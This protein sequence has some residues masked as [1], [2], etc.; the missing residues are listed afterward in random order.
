MYEKKTT[1]GVPFKD[2]DDFD[3]TTTGGLTYDDC[4]TGCVP[5]AM[6]DEKIQITPEALKGGF[7]ADAGKSRV[8]LIPPEVILELGKLYAIGAVKY[9]DDNW[10]LGMDYKRVY[11]AMQRHALKWWA[12]EELD[13]VDGQHHLDSVIWCAVALRYYMLHY[14]KYKDFDSRY[15]K[16]QRAVEGNQK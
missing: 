9:D 6:I 16:P 5:P 15:V 4:P 8:D 14:E 2:F 11:A 1:A 12:G 3:A 13:P 10:K 7:K